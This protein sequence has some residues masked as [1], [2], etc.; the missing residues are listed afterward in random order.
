MNSRG[1]QSPVDLGH[2]SKCYHARV[3]APTAQARAGRRVHRSHPEESVT[4]GPGRRYKGGGARR[5]GPGPD[6]RTADALSVGPPPAPAARAA[7]P[8][9]RRPGFRLDI[10]SRRAMNAA[11]H[12]H[13]CGGAWLPAPPKRAITSP[14]GSPNR[15]TAAREA[16]GPSAQGYAIA[17]IMGSPLDSVPREA[18]LRRRFGGASAAL[19]RRLLAIRAT[20]VGLGETVPTLGWSTPRASVR[21]DS[22]PPLTPCALCRRRRC[23]P[24]SAPGCRSGCQ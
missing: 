19:R 3:F 11:P 4:P 16:T 17:A 6:D 10:T 2:R 23:P 8:R 21:Y 22:P 12:G 14:R 9:D 7:G 24:H 15:H 5:T 20:V 13:Q 1:A 18:A